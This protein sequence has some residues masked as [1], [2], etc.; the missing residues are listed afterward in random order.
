VVGLACRYL[1]GALFLIAAV[2]KITNLHAFRDYLTVQVGLSTLPAFVVAAVLPWLELVCGL[3]LVSGMA[4]REAAALTAVLLVVFLVHGLVHP[5]ESDCG[6]GLWP[7]KLSP[8]GRP[9]LLGRDL[10]LLAC[11]LVASLR[12]E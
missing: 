12:T 9:W 2:S 6:C 4:S 3:C 11:S 7:V 8:P 10:L 1:L 5:V